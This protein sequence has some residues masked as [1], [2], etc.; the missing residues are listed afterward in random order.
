M[1]VERINI[2]LAS[3]SL[4]ERFAET[5]ISEIIN[6]DEPLYKVGR[7]LLEL[8][9]ENKNADD[10]IIAICGWSVDSLLDKL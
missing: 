7:Q 6:D 8:C 3:E 5:L 2:I 1:D 4:T 10:F 9:L